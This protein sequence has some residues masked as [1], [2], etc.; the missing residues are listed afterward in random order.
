MSGEPYAICQLAPKI[1]KLLPLLASDKDGEV[2]ATA[3]AIGR[4]LSAAG[5]D[6]HD[7]V[8]VLRERPPAPEPEFELPFIV[9]CLHG[10]PS[11]NGWE[12]KFI[13]SIVGQQASGRPLTAKQRAAVMRAWDRLQ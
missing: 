10:H 1:A 7:L 5:A 9:R 6:W 8:A 3:R 12:S 2:V 4:T 11:L 13:A